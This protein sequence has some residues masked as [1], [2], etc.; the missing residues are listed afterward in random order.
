MKPIAYAFAALIFLAN[1]AHAQATP[2]GVHINGRHLNPAELLALQYRI[3][4]YI[5]PGDYRVNN[6]TGCWIN[7]SNGRSGC[8]RYAPARSPADRWVSPRELRQGGLRG[9]RPGPLTTYDFIR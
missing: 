3:G 1:A 7:R 6:R 9:V 8:L 4:S 5:A 2:T